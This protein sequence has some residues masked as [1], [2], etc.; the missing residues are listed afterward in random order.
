M[1][2][3]KHSQQMDPSHIEVEGETFE[4][5]DNKSQ[6]N[7][8]Y[9]TIRVGFA[10][11]NIFLTFETIKANILKHMRDLERHKETWFMKAFEHETYIGAPFQAYYDK[12]SS[13]GAWGGTLER[14]VAC[15]FYDIDISVLYPRE[16][17]EHVFLP[18]RKEMELHNNYKISVPK[19][20]LHMAFVN[21]IRFYGRRANH[22]MFLRPVNLQLTIATTFTKSRATSLLKNL[23]KI[24]KPIF[25][26]HINNRLTYLQSIAPENN[27]PNDSSDNP[28]GQSSGSKRKP[29]INNKSARAT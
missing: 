12:I 5:V 13:P 29:Q 7:C 25:K 23:L 2:E 16:G 20:T 14:L 4:I 3:H 17:H 27:N 10:F 18:A 1:Q 6:G 28:N 9:Q 8:L 21:I 11:H 15:D 22:F 26:L 19:F 24:A